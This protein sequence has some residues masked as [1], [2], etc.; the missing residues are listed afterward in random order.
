MNSAK[1]YPHLLRAADI[2]AKETTFSHPWN[3]KSTIRGT[4]MGRLAGLSRTGV[5]LGRL[6]PGKESFAYHSH[7]TEEEWLYV[8]SGR[9]VALVDGAEITLEPGD[10][11][12]FPT[13]SVAHNMSNPFD[14]ELVY[15]MGGENK[16]EEIADFPTLGRRM[17]KLQGE[18]TYY[19]LSDGKP[20]FPPKSAAE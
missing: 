19:S 6:A 13:P 20:M 1:P 15:L 9:G 17:V 2:A 4:W 18:I 8:L 5:S 3:P 7:H 14:E 12:A 10:F 11:I 16:P